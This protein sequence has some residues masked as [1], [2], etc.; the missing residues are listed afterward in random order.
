ML[1]SLINNSL[2]DKN[3]V[4]TYLAT[5]DRLF[6]AKRL[7]ASHVMEI[8]IAAGGSI[9]LWRDYFTNATVHGVDLTQDRREWPPLKKDPRIVLH[10]GAN[11]Y[12]HT[13]FKTTFL[14]PGLKFDMILD[15]GPHTLESMKQFITYYTQVLKDDGILVIEDVQSIDWIP[16]LRKTVPEALQQYIQV[17]DL[18]SNKRR[19]DDI[20]FAINRSGST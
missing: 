6:V 20:I 17:Y 13:F 18:R 8:G 11:A 1:A 4:H 14:D 10:T 7:T 5:Y 19:Y 12:D 9:K 16:E 2:S 3:T 15:D